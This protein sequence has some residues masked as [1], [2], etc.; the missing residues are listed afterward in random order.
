MGESY[1]MRMFVCKEMRSTTLE[2]LASEQLFSF[3]MF[4]VL[5]YHVVQFFPSF[6]FVSRDHVFVYFLN[7]I[8]PL[9]RRMIIFDK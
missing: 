2:E 7:E 8:V 6:M 9:S 1:S 4:F 3:A 5:D